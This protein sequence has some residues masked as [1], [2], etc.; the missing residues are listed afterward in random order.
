[1]EAYKTVSFPGVVNLAK[2]DGLA[3]G[4]RLAKNLPEISYGCPPGPI[5]SFRITEIDES[6]HFMEEN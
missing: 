4:I 3:R 2:L 6:S 1:M 5:P